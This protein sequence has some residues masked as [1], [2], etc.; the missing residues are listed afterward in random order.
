MISD[1]LVSL[2]GKVGTA[3]LL[4]VGGLACFIWRFN[5]VLQSAHHAQAA[6]LRRKWPMKQRVAEAVVPVAKQKNNPPKRS[7]NN[8]LKKEALTLVTLQENRR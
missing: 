1:W 7:K 3:A 2:M 6:G 4:L 5:P 8:K